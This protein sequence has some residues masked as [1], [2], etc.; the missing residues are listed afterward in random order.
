MAVNTSDQ[1]SLTFVGLG[2]LLGEPLLPCIAALKHTIEPAVQV[3]SFGMA[4][5]RRTLALLF[6]YV[7]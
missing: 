3:A 7:T 6:S 1:A 5:D 2:L 4:G